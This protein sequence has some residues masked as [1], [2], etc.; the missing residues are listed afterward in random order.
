MS[1]AGWQHKKGSL[2]SLCLWPEQTINLDFENKTLFN[3][4]RKYKKVFSYILS[5]STLVSTTPNYLFSL[6]GMLV[7]SEKADGLL[8]EILQVFIILISTNYFSRPE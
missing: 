1:H 2:I 3:N 5:Y 4:V 6:E 8:G 7:L